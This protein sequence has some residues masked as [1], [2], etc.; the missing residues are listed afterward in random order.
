[1]KKRTIIAILIAFTLTFGVTA[2]WNEALTNVREGDTDTNIIEQ[3]GAQAGK[4]KKGGNAVVSALKAPFKAIGRLFGKGKDDRLQ[5]LSEKD[6]EKFEAA[7]IARVEDER[8]EKR[9]SSG[10]KTASSS[11]LEHLTEGRS[12]LAAGRLNE[13]IA[14]LSLAASL[15]PRLTEAHS[16]LGVAFDRKGMSERARESYEQAVKTEPEDAQTLNNLG[17]SLYL[18]GNYRA[19]VDRLKR[20]AKL[21]PTDERIL[22]NLALAQCR[23][24]KYRDA[25]K[26][27]TRAGGEYMGRINTATMLERAGRDAEA[28]EQYEAARKVQPTST[29]VLRRLADLYQRYG[30]T[31]E[32]QAARVELANMSTEALASGGN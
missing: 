24:G 8:S 12:L 25:L 31:N 32:A 26:S 16:L 7:G 23:L 3:N 5:R 19:A 9:S 17:Y 13:A 30:R 18:N 21:A 10:V 27:F 4:V 28:I 14:E 29:V 20:A 1:M 11:A 15:D 2:I 6:V 22:N